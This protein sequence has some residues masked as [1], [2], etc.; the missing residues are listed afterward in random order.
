MSIRLQLAVVVTLTAATLVIAGSL[1]LEASLSSGIRATV[2]DSLSRRAQR[3][4]ADL[5]A[6]ALPLVGGGR[7]AAPARDQSVAQV[8]SDA[9]AVEYT[10]EGAGPVRL[11]SR[12]QVAAAA[13]T[14]VF[15]TVDRRA[16]RNPRFL[17]AEPAAGK[18]GRV[19]V[20]GA[21][22]DEL[23]SSLARVREWLVLIGPLLVV[24]AGTG[25]WVLAGRALRPVEQLRLE[26]TTISTGSPDRRLVVPAPRDEIR[27]LAQ[28]LNDLLD[29]L[30]GALARQKEFVTAASHELRTPLAGIGAELDVARQPGRSLEEVRASLDIVGR[31]V[32]QM[33][34]LTRDLLLI[35][36]GD[37]NELSL[38]LAMR[39]LEP[40]A[41]DALQS[42]RHQADVQGVALVLDAE[43]AVTA[44]VDANRFRQ[45]VANLVENA[46]GH[47]TGTRSVELTLRRDADWVTVEVGDRGPGFPAGYLPRAFERFSRG[48]PERSRDTGG[49]GLG[50]AIVRVLVEAHG[51]TVEVRNRDGGGALVRARFPARERGR[52]SGSTV[53]P[54]GRAAGTGPVPPTSIDD[55][56]N[57]GN[58]P[59]S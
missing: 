19:L 35:A 22:L 39:P 6:G 44:S 57:E 1:A 31:E 45:V 58:E 38:D 24:I 59:P 32:G 8:L 51:G 53:D 5:A 47:A 48:G 36:R 25:G 3:V 30:Q 26:A 42:L 9:G 43:P 41:V 14:R 52:D 13:R 15:V 55:R 11:L 27:R 50:L 33:S 37:E 17:L 20:V 10:T 21:S 56:H 18:P 12:R 46:L 29:R 23:D 4:A 16:W 7:P 54:G 2:H 49:T 40:L 34:L 28:T